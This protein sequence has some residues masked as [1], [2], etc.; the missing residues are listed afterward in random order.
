MLFGS[1]AH[2]IYNESLTTGLCG[3]MLSCVQHPSSSTRQAL[4]TLGLGGLS[5]ALLAQDGQRCSS[6]LSTVLPDVNDETIFSIVAQFLR[7]YPFGSRSDTHSDHDTRDLAETEDIEG[8]ND[9]PERPSQSIKSL[10]YYIA[11]EQAHRKA[12]EHR[13]ITC[14]ECGE[15][16]IRGIRWHCL[17]CPDFDL[18]S[19]CEAHSDHL[20]THVFAKIRIPLP[21]L[22]QPSHQIPIWYPGD[23]RKIHLPLDPSSRRRIAQQYDLEEPI[24]DAYYEQFVCIANVPWPNDPVKVQTAIDE[25]AFNKAL[26][27]DRW[28]TRFSPNVLYDRMFAFYDSNNDGLIGFEEFVSGLNYLRG[29]L[30]FTPLTRALRGF[31]ID[32][33]G[34][35]DRTD[36]LRLFRAKYSVHELLVNSM[37]EMYEDNQ[38]LSVVEVLHS[39]QPISSVFH[40]DE[41]PQGEDRPRRGKRLDEFGD[42]QPLPGTKT[43]LDDSDPWPLED[44]VRQQYSGLLGNANPQ[45]GLRHHLSRFE[46]MLYGPEDEGS[47]SDEAGH[48]SATPAPTSQPDQPNREFSGPLGVNDIKNH[49]QDL[50]INQD[51]LL[52]VVENGMNEML[53]RMF[54][55]IEK[56]HRDAVQTRSER[57]RWR[58]NIDLVVNEKAKLE[59]DVLRQSAR[60][61]PL[62]ATASYHYDALRLHKSREEHTQDAS[63][64]SQIVATDAE[65]LSRREED[66]SRQPLEE[67]LSVTGYS[68]TMEPDPLNVSSSFIEQYP[69]SNGNNRYDNNTEVERRVVK[70]AEETP[71][72]TLPQ[73]RPNALST[74]GTDKMDATGVSDETSLDGPQSERSVEV[75][76][77]KQHLE[78]LALLDDADR[79]IEERGGPGR[80]SLDEIEAIA[81]AETTKEIRGMIVSWLDWA[82]F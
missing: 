77:S 4:D 48:T 58:K 5:E 55:V 22:S 36:F 18:C 21:V 59:K 52:R 9:S 67:L 17:N 62:M 23:P 72:P 39:S 3:I 33:D 46:E 71:D 28:K 38:S 51:I 19:T 66:I 74:E 80:L 6:M 81:L 8:L 45:E 12:Y 27:S 43:V 26:T 82:S 68:T 70:S 63:F 35:V 76:P 16:P 30:R 31:D 64:R 29:S 24:I 78:Y 41:I 13:G 56:Q 20:K 25:R 15:N 75:P 11:E 10:L 54:K 14:E 60:V 32:S 49:S 53:D 57:E 1:S 44:V 42:M 79:E 40:E 61:D 65:S 34:F 73:N 50:P 7:T 2:E 37:V 47:G 69:D